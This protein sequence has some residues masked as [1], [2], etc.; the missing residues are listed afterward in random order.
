ML[1]KIKT[2]FVFN[3]FSSENR[4]VYEIMW[5]AR[6]ETADNTM[7][8]IGY[9]CWIT[10]ATAKY[11]EYA[12]RFAFSRQQCLHESASMLRLYVHLPSCYILYFY[13]ILTFSTFCIHGM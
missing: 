1:E 12:I 4:T 6:Q 2:H 5:K 10:K 8:R 11:S 9:A 7:L 3:K 13:L